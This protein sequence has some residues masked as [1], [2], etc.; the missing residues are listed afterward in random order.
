MNIGIAD[1]IK[2]NHI[3]FK[4]NLWEEYTCIYKLDQI[5]FYS[6]V[7]YTISVDNRNKSSR[8]ER[9]KNPRNQI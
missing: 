2:K 1:E 3:F 7:V 9:K 8:L 6:N 5:F 4:R